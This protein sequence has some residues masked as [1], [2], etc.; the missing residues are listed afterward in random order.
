MM[1]KKLVNDNATLDEIS[2]EIRDMDNTQNIATNDLDNLDA[3]L[4]QIDTDQAPETY[5]LEADASTDVT[6]AETEVVA[7]PETEAL[8]LDDLGLEELDLGPAEVEAGEILDEEALRVVDLEMERQ[9]A[10]QAQTAAAVVTVE[11][12][13]AGA[14]KAKTPRTGSGRGSSVPRAARDL[15]SVAEEFFVLS[16][17]AKGMDAGQLTAAKSSTIALK[18]VQ[19]KIAE[20][21]DNLFTAV[22]A[23]KLPSIYT[24]VAFRLLDANKKITSGDLIAAYKTALNNC[25]E[26]TARSQ[27]G[28]LMNLLSTVKIA[29]RSGNT[30][31]L[32][33]DSLLAARIREL[34]KPVAPAAAA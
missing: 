2:K 10:Y 1:Y 20:K 22:A 28:Q 3:V 27:C 16:G 34:E 29:D 14:A 5:T 25:G 18:P 7:A 30:L 15:N 23:G 33:S 11:K 19:V 31:E 26:G 13:P 8:D 24:M 17:D 9:E 4:A 6:E 32:R 21:F 12:Q